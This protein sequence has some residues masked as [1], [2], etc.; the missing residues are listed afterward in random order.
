MKMK[1]STATINKIDE[2]IIEI[3]YDNDI[4]ENLDTVK[5]NFNVSIKLAEEKEY[6]LLVNTSKIVFANTEAREFAAESEIAKKYL[7]KVAILSNSYVGS[8][9]ANLFN[10]TNGP[11]Y[12]FKLFHSKEKAIEWLKKKPTEASK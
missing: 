1:T 12:P 7:K 3:I 9:L 6:L 11:P 4:V 5:E 2:D 10:R 8:A